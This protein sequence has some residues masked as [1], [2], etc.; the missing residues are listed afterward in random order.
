VADSSLLVFDPATGAL[1]TLVRGWFTLPLGMVLVE[2]AGRPSLLVA[3]PFGYRFI[4]TTTGAVTRPPWAG[5]RGASSAVVADRQRIVFANGPAGRLRAVD[6]ASEQLL[7]D[8]TAV[9]TPRGLALLADGS[10]VVADA[11]SGRLLKFDGAAVTE[12]ASGL[13]Q[14]VAVILESPQALLV[15]EFGAGRVQRVDW[16]SGRRQ[17]VAEGLDRP[18]GIARLPDGR[19]AVVEANARRVLAVDLRTKQRTVLAS[20]L[21]L[22]LEGLDLPEDSLAGIVVDA[23]GAIYLSCPGDNS[24]V[25]LRPGRAIKNKGRS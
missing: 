18:A 14:P 19:L 3:D 11:A 22:S 8:S 21:P 20:K 16:R 5:N 12:L 15:S 13:Q 2:H 6:R 25:V 17:V 1:Q 23:A 7:W 24:I 10:V 9:K 4:D